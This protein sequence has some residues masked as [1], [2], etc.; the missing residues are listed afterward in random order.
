LLRP[1]TRGVLD[2]MTA[3]DLVSALLESEIE[4]ALRSD[5][6]VRIAALVHFFVGDDY[7]SLRRT[8]R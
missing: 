7:L 1:D 4:P 6:I 5:L 8:L 2:A 3:R